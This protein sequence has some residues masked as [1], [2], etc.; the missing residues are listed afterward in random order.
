[1]TNEPENE[2]AT[3]EAHTTRRAPDSPFAVLKRFA[4]ARRPVE[5][6]EMCSLELSPVHTHL[7][8]PSSRQLMCAC[9]ACAL[10]FDNQAET[11]YKR[12]PRRVRHLADFR[13]TDAQWDSLMIPIQLAFF[14]RSSPEGRTVAFYPSPAGAT[15]SLLTLDAWSE[16]V[17]ENPALAKME[18]DVEALLVNRV[19]G[20]G[21]GEHFIVPIDECYKLVGLIRANWRG[22]SGGAEVWEKIENFFAALR[23]RADVV[24]SS[25]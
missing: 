1:M 7:V 19:R 16:I 11:K 4:R 22:F 3:G 13:L 15:E 17:E 5:R 12:V 9:D 23:E 10:L 14:F 2:S 8:E 18:A 6:C 21:S 20:A 24:T 25:T